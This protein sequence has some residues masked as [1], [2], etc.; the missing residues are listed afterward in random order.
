MAL[1]PANHPARRPAAPGETTPPKPE[2]PKADLSKPPR[3]FRPIDWVAFLITVLV[4]LAG[5]LYTCAPDLT[6]EDSG[7]LAVASMY[8]GVPHPPGYPVWTIYTW[9]FTKIIPFGNIAWRVAVS[10]AV[11]GALSCGLIAMM[12]SRGSSMFIES[13]AEFKSI[14]RRTENWMCLVTG[15]VSGMLMGFNGFFWSQAVIVEVY[16]IS[17]LSLVGVLIFLLRWG[18]APHQYRYLYF[19]WFLCGI[20]FNNHQSLVVITMAME[21]FMI[22]VQARLG[23][24]MMLWNSVFFLMGM[25]LHM[26]NQMSLMAGN[27]PV[28]LIFYSVG[29]ASMAAW[30]WLSVKIKANGTEVVRDLI[31]AGVAFLG[32]VA[33][34]KTGGLAGIG[35]V[36]ALFAAMDFMS[37][38]QVVA[39]TAH[40]RKA[41]TSGVMFAIGVAF[42]LYMP[43]S[44]MTNPPLNWGYPRTAAGFVHAFTRGQYEKIHPTAGVGDNIVT[45]TA[46][47][48]VRYSEQF[49]WMLI[50]GA[51]D[52]FNLVYL[53]IGFIPLL[54]L[55]RVQARERAWLIGLVAFYIILGPFMLELLNPQP[56]RQ[57]LSLNKVF[58]TSANVIIAMAIGHGLTFLLASLLTGY[59]KFRRHALIGFSLCAGLALY[60][61]YRTYESTPYFVLRAAAVSGFV[62]A[63]LGALIVVVARHQA[64]VKSLLLVFALMPVYP[65][66][67]HW[68][69]NEQRGHMFGFWFGHDMFTPPFKDKSGKLSYLRKDREELL[70]TSEGKATVYPE[71][72]K[73]AILFGGTDPGRFCPTYMIFCESFIAPK[74]RANP[75]FDRRD[76]YI[77]TQNA[78]ADGT[79][80]NYIRAHYFRSD[81]YQYDTPF[82][83]DWMRGDEEK[84][85]NFKTNLLARLV[86]VPLDRT[87]T[88][89][90]DDIEYQRRAGDS[91]F[92]DTD[93]SDLAGFANKLK[94]GQPAGL[95]QY[96]RGH[97]SQETIQRLDGPADKNLASLLARDLNAL[98]DKEFADNRE[99]NV[100]REQLK[101]LKLDPT[102]N[103]ARIDE[104]QKKLVA[105]EAA[106]PLFTPARFEGV[107]V[108]DYLKHFLA[109]APQ[110]AYAR[111][112]LNRLLIEAAYP[113]IARAPGGL[114]PDTEIYT[115]TPEDSQR[116]FQEYMADAQA[117][118]AKGQL[119]PGED[120]RVIDNRVQVSGQVAV[121][122]IN[123][124]LTKVIFDKNP[125]KEFF[126]EES[127]PLDWMYPHLTPFGI[128]MKINREPLRELSE[129][130]LKKDHQFWSDYSERLIGNW[131]TYDTPVKEVVEFAERVYVNKDYTGF[132]GDP[133]F[134]RDEDGQKAF[135]KLRSSISG[136]YAER[137]RTTPRG[138]AAYDR[139][140]RE[141]EFSFKQAY[142]FCPYSPEALY[143]YVNLLAGVGRFE[144]ALLLAR[145]SQKLD[146][147][148]QQLGN[149]AKE[150][151]RLKGGNP[152]PSAQVPP[153]VLKA[154]VAYRVNPAF[155]NAVAYAQA[156]ASIGDSGR[157]SRVADDIMANAQA[158]GGMIQFAMQIYAQLQDYAKL[159]TALA[160]WAAMNPAPESFL[161]LAG[162]QAMQS[163]H[164]QAIATLA[165]ALS[166]NAARLKADPKAGNLAQTVATDPRFG[167]LQALPEFKAM[168]ATNK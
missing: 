103:A 65:I 116:C 53:A 121:M 48:V 97:F 67:S 106:A 35:I 34:G 92:K 165:K 49:W 95:A 32:T 161:D 44:S 159:E 56:D 155:S 81:Q 99:S 14:A 28:I 132:K 79:Y 15:F 152:G 114:Y 135:S 21:V 140:L 118:M 13:V 52:E 163:K 16:T 145:T 87:F 144:D 45:Q 77:I 157:V 29:M 30:V 41:V 129:E 43:L 2:V 147:G 148:N 24:Q 66:L 36:L 117:R 91:R 112:R 146:P 108:A 19:A 154:E 128:I 167:A 89:L 104:T 58:F 60:G 37:R 62:L 39:W 17:V 150:L 11:A 86:A 93:F 3:L 120:V 59:D 76:V 12:V 5:Y 51:E 149:L 78:L 151:E 113:E 85:K 168:F 18:Y 25:V 162:A 26:K 96:L 54:F 166:L 82:F 74:D 63:L 23:R 127:F 10:S 111:A 31:M 107:V 64:P 71:M 47:W 27:T 100:I 80:L 164:P 130:I 22:A 98:L 153:A 83:Q 55:R 134:V 72:T 115:P 126:V 4:T 105:L 101:A 7:E 139:V 136:V 123:G 110:K 138:T 33:G 1:E 8:A 125:D 102:N 38:G 142:A 20:A 143:R 122:A 88:G 70:K 94:A 131:I 137:L 50:R 73:D 6:L 69:D 75:E 68:S 9:F 57:S 42:Y 160:R 141:A 84:E 158:D 119:K 124:L 156:A 61:V 109:Q 90:G 46:S 40:W 133:K